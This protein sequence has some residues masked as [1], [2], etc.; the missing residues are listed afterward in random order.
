MQKKQRERIDKSRKPGSLP[1]VWKGVSKN[2]GAMVGLTLIALILI[3]C[4]ISPLILKYDY[5]AISMRNRFAPP[6]REHLFGCD[7]LGRDILARVL[8]G[9][10]FTLAIGVGAVAISS[11]FGVLIGSCA[12][13]FGG[14]VDFF[15]TRVLDIIQSFPGM[16]S[17]IAITAILG[18]GFGKCI[19]AIG[20]G[21]TPPFARLM[22]ANML[23]I[24]GT[25]FIEAAH[26]INCSTLRIILKHMLPNSIS[27]IIVLMSIQIGLAGLT[28]SALSF[29]GLG[30]RE[31]M[32]EWGAMIAA[33]REFMRESPHMVFIPG[34]FI[35]ITVLSL[36]M[37]GDAIRDALDPRLK[38]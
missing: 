30:V 10:R 9:A 11:F 15:L 18:A 33:S 38:D 28:A 19:I 22:R 27:P 8:Y 34:L 32:P 31:P 3:L 5:W 21:F 29:L 17:S 7:Q 12:G 37:V 20:I 14:K 1:Y 26:A 2:P 25:E 6:N 4:F 35:K 24:R 13:Y 23:S 36:N 16:V